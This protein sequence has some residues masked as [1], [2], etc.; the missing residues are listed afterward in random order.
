MLKHPSPLKKNDEDLFLD[1]NTSVALQVAKDDPSTPDTW[2]GKKGTVEHDTWKRNKKQLNE[3]L[4]EKKPETKKSEVKEKAA[5][6]SEIT[7]MTNAGMTEWEAEDGAKYSLDHETGTRMKNGK[8]VKKDEFPKAY[9]SDYKKEIEAKDPWERTSY[10]MMHLHQAGQEEKDVFSQE[11]SKYIEDLSKLQGS[12]AG[13]DKNSKQSSKLKVFGGRTVPLPD[14]QMSIGGTKKQKWT[15]Y[16]ER[17]ARENLKQEHFENKEGLESKIKENKMSAYVK[18]SLDFFKTQ[19]KKPTKEQVNRKAIELYVAKQEDKHF[20]KSVRDEMDSTNDILWGKGEEQEIKKAQFDDKVHVFNDNQKKNISKGNLYADSITTADG[21]MAELRYNFQQKSDA[22]TERG[23]ELI[24]LRESLPGD[25]EAKIKDGTA[26]QPQ[27]K[28]HEQA[29]EN[30]KKLEE[31][32]EVYKENADKANKEMDSLY[33][34]RD[35]W[36]NLYVKHDDVDKEL[37]DTGE[38]MAVYQK[39]LGQDHHEV[40]KLATKIYGLGVGTVDGLETVY[41]GIKP[42]NLIADYLDGE[43]DEE[44]GEKTPTWAKAFI[45]TN[46]AHSTLRDIGKKQLRDYHKGINEGI[47]PT[48]A[49]EDLES[50]EDWGGFIMDLGAQTVFQA[51]LMYATGGGSLLIMGTAAGGNRYDQLKED[52]DKYGLGLSRG[53]M[54]ANS[55]TYGAGEAIMEVPT[56]QMFKGMKG[57]SKNLVR[58]GYLDGAMGRAKYYATSRGQEAISEAGTAV[59]QNG[60]DIEILGEKKSYWTNVE[61][62]AVSG[63]IMAENFHSVKTLRRTVD[64]FQGAEYDRK[65]RDNEATLR[66]IDDKRRNNDLDPATIKVLDDKYLKVLA[67]SRNIIGKNVENVD[68]MTTKEKDDLINID[69]RKYEAKAAIDAINEDKGLSV[70]DKKSLVEKEE[71]DIAV[72][73]KEKLDILKPFEEKVARAKKTERFE[74]QEKVVK[75]KVAEINKKNKAAG[76]KGRGTVKT[77][78]TR[79]E[80]TADFNDKLMKENAEEA[81]NIEDLKELL[82]DDTVSPEVKKQAQEIIDQGKNIIKGRNAQSKTMNFAHGLVGQDMDSDGNPTG[83]FSIT[84]NK[85]QAVKDENGNVNVAAHEFLHVVLHNTLKQNPELQDKIGGAV[86]EFMNKEKGGFSEGFINKMAPYEGDQNQGE[87]VLTVMSQSIMDGTLKPNDSFLTKMGDVIRQTYQRFGGPF[88]DIKFDTGKDVYNFIKDY[89]AS[90]EKN[91]NSKAIDRVMQQGAKG[92]L[93]SGKGEATNMDQLSKDPST[94][95]ETGKIAAA[96]NLRLNDQIYEEGVTNEDGDLVP[97]E[98]IREQLVENN[99]GM[100]GSLALRAVNNPNIKNLESGKRYDNYND[101]YQEYYIF[102]DQLSRS[103]R[104]DNTPGDFGAYMGRNLQLKY[105]NVLEKLKKGDMDAQSMSDE[106]TMKKA[107]NIVGPSESID[108][109]KESTK[110]YLDGMVDGESLGQE[111]LDIVKNSSAETL[112]TISPN[113]KG[114]KEILTKHDKYANVGTKDIPKYELIDDKF[115]DQQKIEGNKVVEVKSKRVATSEFLNI[116]EATANWYGVDVKRITKEQDLT[117]E[118]RKSIQSRIFKPGADNTKQHINMMPKGTDASGLATGIANTTFGKWFDKLRR[119]KASVTGNTAGNFGQRKQDMINPKEFQE[120]AGIIT[121][122]PNINNTSVDGFLRSLVVQSAVLSFNQ[123]IRKRAEFDGNIKGLMAIKDGKSDYYYSKSPEEMQDFSFATR[124]F[125][126]QEGTARQEELA[127]LLPG[128]LRSVLDQY[129]FEVQQ[130][131]PGGLNNQVLESKDTPQHIKDMFVKAKTQARFKGPLLF[132]PATNGFGTNNKAQEKYVDQV[133]K[134]G[135]T[136]HSSIPSQFILPILGIKDAGTK[137]LDTGELVYAT[138]SINPKAHV[139]LIKRVVDRKVNDKVEAKFMKDNDINSEHLKNAVPMVYK[140]E[141]KKIINEVWAQETRSDKLATLAKYRKRINEINLGNEALLKYTTLKLRGS[142]ISP[143]NHFHMS[144]MQTNIIEGTRAFSSFEWMYLPEGKQMP[145]R[146][147]RNGTFEVVDAP[148]RKSKTLTLNDYLTSNDWNTYNKKWEDTVDYAEVYKYNLEQNTNTEKIASKFNI[149]K[150]LVAQFNTIKMLNPKNEHIGASASTHAERFAFVNNQNADISVFGG[151]H[152]TFWGPKFIMDKYLD[153]K[154]T[155]PITGKLVDNKVS[156]E[157]P[158][159]LIKFTG[160]KKASIFHNDGRDVTDWVADTEGLNDFVNE[161]FIPAEIES[162][163]V[164]AFSKAVNESNKLKEN[165][166][167]SVLDFDDTLAT[168]KSLI[169]F[170]KP[171][172]TKGTLNAEQYA[173]QYQDLTDQ[174][175]KWD[176]SEFNEVV[177]GK[178]A[179]LFQKA[180]KLQGKFGPKNMF[181]LTARPAGAAKAIYK[182]LQANGLKIPMK[183]ITGL[184][185]STGEAKANWMADKVGE[186]YN[187]FYF[188]DDALQNVE[189]VDNMLEKFDVKRKVQQ[190]KLQF[191]KALSPAM[192]DI[193]ES[194]TGI[195][196]EKVFS[197]AQAKIRGARTKYKSIIPA[198]AQDFKGLLYNFIGKGKQGEADMEFFK[199]ALIDPF[200]KGIDRLNT[201]RQSAA[202]DY[203]TLQKAFPEVKKILNKNIEG[204]EFS[205]DQSVRVYLWDKAG[206]DVPGLSKRDLKTLVDH[207]SSN[208]SLKTYADTVGLISQKEAGY[209]KPGDFWLAENIT[210]DLLSDGAIGDARADILTEWQS[211]VDVMFSGENLNKIEAVYGSNFREALED[212]IYRMRTGRNRPAGG[213]RIMNTY[214]NWVNNSVGAIMFFNMRSAILQTISATNYINWSFNNPAKAAVAFAN[215]PQYWKDFSMIFNSPYLK[216]RRSGNQRGINEAEL[217]AAV[218]GAENKAKAA[219]AWLLKK[220]FLPT[221]LADSFAIASGGATFF[222]N[223]VK[224]LVKEGMTQEQAEKQAFLDFQETTEVSQQSARPDMISQQQASPLGRLILSFQNT[225]MQYARIMNKAARDLANGRGDTKTHLSKIAYYG[226]AQSILFG[227]LQSAL[228]ASMGEDEEDEFDKKKERILNGMIDS[229]LSGIGYGGKAVSTAKNSIREYIKQ[230]DKGW[231]ADHTYTILSLLSFSPPIGSK[232]RKIYGSIQTEQF[233]QGVFEK[234]G[235]TLDNPAWSGIGNVVEGVTNV[236]LGRVAQKM[237]NIDN[238][239]DDSNSFFERTALLLGWNT[240]DLGIKDKDIEAVKDEIKVEKKVE[241]KIKQKIKKEEKKIEKAK[242]NE[243]V[244]EENKKKS[245]EDGIC[246]AIS[247]GGNRCKSKAVGGGMCTVHEKVEKNE[248][249][250]KAQCKGSRTNGKQCG[251]TTNSKS[252]YCYY[253]D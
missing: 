146:Q 86:V 223:K 137:L 225:P 165:K 196:S 112:N 204:T 81:A 130:A 200:A 83:D 61:G 152:K 57:L 231:N 171:D 211:N 178:I 11:G 113:Y 210:S 131:L 139:D 150:E 194:T 127:E 218:A 245:K 219:I 252:G 206:F 96:E 111:I 233:N 144:R 66:D 232:L 241:N 170:T 28:K 173:S 47:E 77:F 125:I 167:I 3:S 7:N 106:N 120:A 65:L 192:N 79:K 102:L 8:V 30:K 169:R 88:S 59:I 126:R 78:E 6:T 248:S 213:G 132:D 237:L 198:S 134:L 121:G 75:E 69:V 100:V 149:P 71:N 109:G 70:K 12:L 89:N 114:V 14:P 143:L 189:A 5:E 138:R 174:G 164:M 10:E 62:A 238:A 90:I 253:H 234:R 104:P 92:V 185:N 161:V 240:W 205:N 42:T 201:S 38:D 236:P 101:W 207:V 116:L 43:W 217:S 27:I 184:G 2:E 87:E 16:R 157:G 1:P 188:A 99:L 216:Q 212:S 22:I 50:A 67:D 32:Y 166:G 142:D 94:L 129:M 158:F 52:N 73:M 123:A 24:K 85:E 21:R 135:S 136:I 156:L 56:F 239:L 25:I 58:K 186:G 119:V 45:A 208:P 110:M 103:Y 68:Y 72:L 220:G 162:K 53:Q 19:E 148:A 227:A 175:Y 249:G 29:E 40:S 202:N 197:D 230:K 95:T 107:E 195:K 97:S 35:K 199:K 191:S 4:K 244:I 181:V 41:N 48:K 49:Y 221:Q 147:L 17:N 229:V 180:L 215:Q 242:E 193:L 76:K 55:F 177:D 182:F 163:Q 63:L 247:K 93:V 74:E 250:V 251:M 187:D 209:S 246:S 15:E 168:S 235:L 151:D 226:V 190:A 60:A 36:Y 183:N 39:I 222:R 115:K 118:M 122:A 108:Q 9:N 34:A 51:G 18:E 82:K 141:V 31:D 33:T 64:V 128:N 159:R 154:V 243:A 155:D 176:F 54:R 80:Q 20:E 172:G 124:E 153:A 37:S 179:P 46:K 214:M 91:Y 160:N 13:L 133:T 98:S 23:E 224:A 228:M 84:L 105:G 140:G 203:K 26:T 117:S 145:M 44:S